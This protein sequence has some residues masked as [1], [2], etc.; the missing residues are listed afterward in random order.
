MSANQI[1]DSLRKK[2]S[3][4][5]QKDKQFL[6]DTSDA[7]IKEN[8]QDGIIAV[9]DLL[10]EMMP[11]EYKKSIVNIMYIDGKRLD[12]V[13][14]DLAKII[15]SK[16]L[17]EALPLAEKLYQKITLGFQE[18][19]KSKFVSLR[20]AFEDNLYQIIFK[21]DKILHRTPF[22]FVR[23]I[24]AYAYIL[25][26][27]RELDKAEEVLKKAIEYNPVDC[28][29][30]FELAEVYKLCKDKDKI[31]QIT[32]NTLKIASSPS[33]IARCYA[34]LGYMCVDLEEYD[35]ASVFYYAS[36]LFYPNP[37]INSELRN[38]VTIT[39]QKLVVPN[40]EKIDRTFSKYDTAYGAD[41]KVIEIAAVLAQQYI[42][43][44]DIKNALYCLKIIYGLTN[45][46]KIKDI[47][48]KYEQA[49]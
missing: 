45:D 6:S 11:D 36:M 4:D 8:N 33:A 47:I 19:E 34:N 10:E 16:H 17:Q 43:N 7:Y 26:E 9:A 41:Q 39:G 23:M 14:E 5:F 13:Y 40:K 30:K 20:N 31:I 2:L 28:A 24:M 22:D 44:N 49:E 37:A 1:K 42:E 46:E 29:P 12:K 27:Y 38:I 35:D 15:N 18:D 21:P 32:K 3:G 25:V 48:L